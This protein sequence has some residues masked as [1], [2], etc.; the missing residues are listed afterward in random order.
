MKSDVYEPLT[1]S[2]ELSRTIERCTA[3]ANSEWKNAVTAT[4]LKL[5]ARQDRLTASDI[6]KELKDQPVHT[7]D[8]RA[9]GGMIRI[10]QKQGIIESIGMSRTNEQNNRTVLWRSR[11][12]RLHPNKDD[13]KGQ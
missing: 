9:L 10:A 1:P 6:R 11:L 4:I 12:R 7:E 13:A 2:Q 8:L 5:A 3:H